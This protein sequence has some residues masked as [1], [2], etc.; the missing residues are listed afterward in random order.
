MPS[1]HD[2]LA[3]LLGLRGWTYLIFGGING[4]VSEIDFNTSSTCSSA[5]SPSSAGASG[6]VFSCVRSVGDF[7]ANSASVLK[8][9]RESRTL[10]IEY[11]IVALTQTTDEWRCPRKDSLAGLC[12]L[13]A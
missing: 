4:T 13:L 2:P 6:R 12:R 7:S 1:S 9:W 10:S 8:S 3:D 5:A 11:H